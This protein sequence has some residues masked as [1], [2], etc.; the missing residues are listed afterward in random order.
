MKYIKEYNSL[1]DTNILNDISRIVESNLNIFLKKFEW[2]NE[3]YEH[4]YISYY[5]GV[6]VVILDEDGNSVDLNFDTFTNNDTLSAPIY[7]LLKRKSLTRLYYKRSS[8]K[9]LSMY[10]TFGTSYND[11]E[12]TNL[13]EENFDKIVKQL[14]QQKEFVTKLYEFKND[15]KVTNLDYFYPKFSFNYRMVHNPNKL[16]NIYTKLNK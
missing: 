2:V 12:K 11:N 8:I 16:N 14:D 3:Y 5:F 7:D 15:K 13:D 10:I 6:D 9:E 1:N 4:K